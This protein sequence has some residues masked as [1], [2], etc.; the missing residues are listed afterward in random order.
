VRDL[1]CATVGPA[2]KTTTQ[3]YTGRKIE[4][5]YL[6]PTAARMESA[7]NGSL[8]E[9]LARVRSDAV[10]KSLPRIATG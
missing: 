7:L 3:H 1:V 10:W 2:G 6:W 9:L 4:R 5:T 8:D